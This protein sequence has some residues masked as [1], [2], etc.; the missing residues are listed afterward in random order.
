MRVR[1]CVSQLLSQSLVAAPYYFK[2][3]HGSKRW[4]SNFF[5]FY[6]SSPVLEPVLLRD[7]WRNCLENIIIMLGSVRDNYCWIQNYIKNIYFTENHKYFLKSNFMLKKVS[8]LFVY[9]IS[10][11]LS[12]IFTIRNFSW[13]F[14]AKIDRA[15]TGSDL[16]LSSFARLSIKSWQFP[17][18]TR[19]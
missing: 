11:N 6:F 2:R 5:R 14:W 17:R 3:R 9:F 16:F 12:E 18:L 1:D 4:K 15:L 8:H 10:L 13:N 19:K 7:Y